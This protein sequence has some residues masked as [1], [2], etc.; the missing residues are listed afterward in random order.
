MLDL[1]LHRSAIG[2]YAAAVRRHPADDAAPASESGQL[3]ALVLKAPDT[4]LVTI[5]DWDRPNTADGLEID[6]VPVDG[7]VHLVLSHCS[8]DPLPAPATQPEAHSR[9]CRRRRRPESQV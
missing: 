1:V 3:Q 5:T 2:R 7:R 6:L 8:R 4:S 9:R